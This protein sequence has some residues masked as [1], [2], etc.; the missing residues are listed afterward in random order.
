MKYINRYFNNLINLIYALIACN[1]LP[2]FR[3]IYVFFVTVFSSNKFSSFIFGYPIILF[4]NIFKSSD[5]FIH[6]LLKHNLLHLSLRCL[7]DVKFLEIRE[8]LFSLRIYKRKTTFL[9]DEINQNLSLNGYSKINPRLSDNT[10]NFVLKSID[11]AVPFSSQVPSQGKKISSRSKNSNFISYEIS[12]DVVSSC[13]DM[14]LKDIDFNKLK[15]AISGI[16]TK[17]YS[18]NFYKNFPG[19]NYL[20]PVQNFHKDYDGFICYVLFVAL[21]DVSKNNGATIVVNKRSGC[22]DYLEAKKGDL[23]LLDPF[24]LHRANDVITSNRFACWIRFGEIPN[25]AYYQDLGFR[26]KIIKAIQS[27]SN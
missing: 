14:I 11:D 21:S 17:I 25:L 8:R 16:E 22:Y 13:A 10:L 12:D 27:I 18:I 26:L 2:F 23:Y 15:N 7:N 9:C 20:H 24:V 6:F 1:Y 5:N 3:K 19:S 4:F